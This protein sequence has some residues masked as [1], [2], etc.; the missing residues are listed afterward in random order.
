VP[1]RINPDR[2]WINGA[3]RRHPKDRERRR[4]RKNA[5]GSCNSNAYS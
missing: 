4:R 3:S 5:S 2:K 1:Y